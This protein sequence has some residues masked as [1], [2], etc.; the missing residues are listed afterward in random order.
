MRSIVSIQ[1]GIAAPQYKAIVLSALIQNVILSEN[2][3]RGYKN[4]FSMRKLPNSC[5]F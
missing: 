1:T 4:G 5:P 2:R 3:S